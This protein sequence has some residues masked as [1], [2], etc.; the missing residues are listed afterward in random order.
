M[1]G[2][3]F[4]DF[5]NLKL[6]DICSNKVMLASKREINISDILLKYINDSIEE[7]MYYSISEKQE[8]VMPLIDNGYV[9]KSY[10]NTK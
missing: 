3:D 9:I 4:C 8:K 10:P 5:V 2:K 6:E 1:K 7:T